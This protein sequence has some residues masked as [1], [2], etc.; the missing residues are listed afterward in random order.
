MNSSSSGEWLERF[1]TGKGF[2]IVL[3]LCAA[4]IGGSAWMLAVGGETAPGEVVTIELSQDVGTRAA[5]HFI[6][7]ELLQRGTVVNHFAIRTGARPTT[8]LRYRYDGFYSYAAKT[9][10]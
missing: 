4:V 6:D 7:G 2:Y 5:S 1:L 8:L 10:L 9:F 3:F